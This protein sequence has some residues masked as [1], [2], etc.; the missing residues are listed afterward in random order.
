MLNIKFENFAYEDG[1]TKLFPLVALN[2][3]GTTNKLETMLLIQEAVRT[4]GAKAAN[5]P[6]DRIAD[7]LS[8]LYGA[9]QSHGFTLEVTV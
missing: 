5:I 9:A 4:F 7:V 1:D 6:S 3:D 2:E 8:Q